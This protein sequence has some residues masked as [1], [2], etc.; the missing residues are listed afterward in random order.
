M[1]RLT[2]DV[3]L[4]A[5]AF[6]VETDAAV[7]VADGATQSVQTSHRRRRD[8]WLGPAT[9][10]LHSL[11]VLHPPTHH[12]CS[13]DRQVDGQ[14][15]RRTDGRTLV[16]HRRS[17]LAMAFTVYLQFAHLHTAIAPSVPACDRQTDR[18]TDERTNG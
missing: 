9:A 4:S 6:D 1:R 13:R 16:V 15:D 5:G 11:L 17:G 7:A 14:T 18:R 8:V 3:V 2:G 10:R 12:T